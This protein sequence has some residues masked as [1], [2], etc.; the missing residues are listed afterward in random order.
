MNADSHG[1]TVAWLYVWRVLVRRLHLYRPE[2]SQCPISRTL[3]FLP[4]ETG[5]AEED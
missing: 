4:P 3:S 2:P 5:G 1:R